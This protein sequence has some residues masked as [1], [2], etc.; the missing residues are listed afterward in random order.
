MSEGVVLTHVLSLTA[1][2]H[3]HRKSGRKRL[4]GDLP[5]L[6]RIHVGVMAH[7]YRE[8]YEA[9]EA[10]LG[11][12]TRLAR[13]E[14]GRVAVCWAQLA[15]ATA[16]L[17]DAYR[18]R[19]FGKGRRPSAQQV[20]RLARRQGLSDSSYS[21]ALDRLRELT[22]STRHRQPT[23]ALELVVDKPRGSA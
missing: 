4:K 15:Q 13:L 18:R 3:R 5:R 21:Q 2:P 6:L 19:Q 11:P 9:L 17:T 20:E 8:A 12:F 23:S 16:A 10:D 22:K 1:V 7:A 14:A